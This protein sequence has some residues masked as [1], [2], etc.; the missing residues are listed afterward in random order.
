M[1]ARIDYQTG[2]IQKMSEEIVRGPKA[3]KD[4]TK[5]QPGFYIMR[6]K[7][8]CASPQP[9]G[10]G[11]VFIYE[12]DGR[13]LNAA[14]LVG[15]IDDENIIKLLETTEGF[16]KLVSKIGVCVESAEDDK[17][18]DFIFQM[19]GK[20]DLYGG[21]ANIKLPVKMD[22]MEYLVD[23]QD[24][25]WQEDDD[26]PG[27]IRF[28][29]AKG[30]TKAIV[31]VK[32][33]LNDGYNAPEPEEE[34]PVD[35]ESENYKKIIAKSLF[36]KGN[37]ARI[38]KALAKART[39]ELTTVA[40]IGGSI[41]QGAGAVPINTECYAYRTFKGFCDLAGRSVDDNV[42][43]IKAGVGGTPSEYGML[44]YDRDVVQECQGEGPD[45]VVVEFAV[46]DEGDETKGECF[47][48]IIR[49][50]Y[51]GPGKPAVIIEF[52]VFANDWN[53]QDRLKPVGYAYNIPM[54]SALDSVV[55]QFKLTYA[56]GRVLS[57]SQFFYD[58]FHPT[59]AGH[60]IMADGILNLIR[61][62]DAD[63]MDE[64]IADLAGI[65]APIGSEF[66]NVELLDGLVNNCG[67]IID[68][69]DFTDTDE[70]LQGVERN[71]D[72][73]LSPQLPNNWMYRGSQGRNN[74][75]FKLD[76]EAS[77]ILLI[78][79]DSA[80]NKDG[81][82]KVWVDGE[83]VLTANPRLVGWTHCD[84]VI[85]LRGAQKKVHHVE[86]A[87]ESDCIDKDFTILGFGIVR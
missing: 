31:A 36:Y 75:P 9:D 38:K 2:E 29:F 18:C 67:A 59:N 62:A 64:E 43:Y 12:S 22:G 84:P 72:L 20:K 45:L 3:P 8:V 44:R 68:K 32:F 82:A 1:V 14:K 83:E 76:V 57:K 30:G 51:E 15:N 52:A 85:I 65:V 7:E 39:G 19:Y 25:D 42:K 50:I 74:R 40:F 13:L 41:T 60:R 66:E 86:I 33:Y 73:T 35:Y 53:L 37:N 54:V 48:S 4:P 27:Q 6:N 79:K 77:A 21:G 17:Y 28:E 5:K 46:N 61:V 47:D 80:D 63:E 24:V 70:I 69:G 26:V 71:L 58:M 87:M 34:N 56:E 78:F 16:R 49:K 81:R 11:I 55:E 10:R 23:M